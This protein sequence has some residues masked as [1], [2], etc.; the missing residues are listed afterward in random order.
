MTPNGENLH[1]RLEKL[2]IPYELHRLNIARREPT[3]PFLIAISRNG[4]ILRLVPE[5][6]IQPTLVHGIYRQRCIIILS[7]FHISFHLRNG[8]LG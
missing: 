4:Q 6:A 2:G 3:L 7:T 1:T 8:D 5:M